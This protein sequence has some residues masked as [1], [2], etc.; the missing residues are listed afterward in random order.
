M[1][2][3]EHLAVGAG[4]AGFSWLSSIGPTCGWPRTEEP[5]ARGRRHFENCDEALPHDPAL[6]G[7]S[8]EPSGVAPHALDPEAA[9]RLWEV[10]VPAL[11]D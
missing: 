9:A 2:Q 7:R 6:A 8:G 1:E 5:L 3:D 10:S 4:E 11:G